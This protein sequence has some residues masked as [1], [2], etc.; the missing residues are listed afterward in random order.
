S[1]DVI[2]GA[3]VEGIAGG[4]RYQ[5]I[6]QKAYGRNLDMDIPKGA[7]LSVLVENDDAIGAVALGDELKPTSKELI[8]ALKKNN[9][10]PIMATGDNEK[11][12]QGA[13]EDL[14]IEYRSNQSPQDKYELVKTLKDEGK[15]VIMV[16]DGVNDAPSLA[17]A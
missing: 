12:A 17:L 15:K 3:G 4:H 16:G 2:S 7:T 5:L 6:S 1:I 11:A 8:K 14:G 10:Q 9:I 13:A